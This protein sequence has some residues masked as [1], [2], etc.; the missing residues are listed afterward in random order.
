MQKLK[1]Y[2][3]K[4]F[5]LQAYSKRIQNSPCFICDM[6]AGHNPHHIIYQDE[7]AVA[8]LNKY[9][10]L[11]GYVLV[12]PCQHKEQMTSDFSKDEYLALQSLIYDLSEAIKKVVP[13]ERIY[14]LSLGSQQGNAHVHW[15]L[16][17][18]PPG[19]PFEK[20]QFEALKIEQ[21]VLD[22]SEEE[23]VLLAQQIHDAMT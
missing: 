6:L 19:V 8:F 20:Q 2:E 9:P 23:L 15:H 1:T 5:D 18:L 13:T 17:P 14:V 4:S 3:T 22:I 16:A 11:Y 21:G 10:S 7:C 12:A